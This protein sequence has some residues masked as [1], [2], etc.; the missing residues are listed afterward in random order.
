[1]CCAA[2]ANVST[3]C[4]AARTII[5]ATGDT[6]SSRKKKQRRYAR[7]AG[8]ETALVSLILNRAFD[9]NRALLFRHIDGCYD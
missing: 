7:P 3:Q 9:S 5:V 6:E 4:L 1:M 8:A 2:S